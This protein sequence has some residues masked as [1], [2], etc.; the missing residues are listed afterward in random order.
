MLIGSNLILN[1]GT[2]PMQVVAPMVEE[3]GLDA[4]FIGEHTHTPVA[5]TNP[6]YPDGLPEFYKRFPDPFVQ[7]G[8]AAALTERVRLGFGILL[9]AER[10]PLEVA[11]AVATLDM[12]SGGRVELGVGYGW[13]PLE[14]VNNGID[15]ATRRA[16]LREKLAA[17][18]RLWTEDVAGFDGEFV[19]FTDSWSYPKPVQKPHP[20]ILIGG[21]A[22]KANF[23]DVVNLADG[24]YPEGADDL[25]DKMKI[26]TERAGGVLPPVTAVEMEGQRPG[27]PWYID[28]QAALTALTERA[29][30]YADGGVYR[31]QVGVPTDTADRLRQALEKLAAISAAVA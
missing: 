28:D 15:P 20:P 27:V 29:R 7:L 21:T 31:L 9:V 13:N 19:N 17:I 11:K 25:L 23:D 2:L 4:L 18:R 14:M 16:V 24:W 6:E 12:V 26:L 1:D 5:T 30:R 22:T 3:H 8:V 10:S